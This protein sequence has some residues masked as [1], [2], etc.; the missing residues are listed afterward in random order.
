MFPDLLANA[1]LNVVRGLLDDFDDLRL[2]R[3]LAPSEEI[4]YEELCAVE[5]GLLAVAH[6]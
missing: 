6:G 4:K 2:L 3:G 1:T 5:G